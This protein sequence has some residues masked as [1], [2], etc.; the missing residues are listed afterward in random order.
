LKEV[1]DE[2][3]KRNETAHV[4]RG[5][6]IC[7]EKGSELPKGSPGRKMEGRVVFQGN[8]VLDQ[9]YDIA[10]FKDLGS[11]PATMEA[12]KCVDAYGLIAGHDTEQADGES[13]YTQTELTGIDTWVRLPRERWPEKCVSVSLVDPVCRLRLALYGHPDAGGMWEAHC[14]QHMKAIGFT[15]V[16]EKDIDWRLVFWHPKLKLL[17][18]VYVDD[19][20]LSGPAENLKKGWDQITHGLDG[21]TAGIKIEAPSP[22]GKYLDCHHDTGNVMLTAGFNYRRPVDD[23]DDVEEE[24]S[25]TVAPLG[26]A[27]DASCAPVKKKKKKS[28]KVG[29][30]STEDKEVQTMKR[31]MSSFL[32][33]CFEK[34]QQLSGP[35]GAKLKHVDTP[36]LDES[37]P[38]FDKLDDDPGAGQLRAE[39]S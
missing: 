36:F 14:N 39:C 37:K 12:G 7:V 1:R 10:I 22:T 9:N 19:F 18:T 20:K 24:Q 21:K 31:N 27:G 11:A 13:A 28:A 2:A 29:S 33:Q 38:E 16:G 25:L 30:V 32:E 17:L 15:E 3:R 26:A 35:L 4:G 23:Q 34:C 5:F 6:D 8:G